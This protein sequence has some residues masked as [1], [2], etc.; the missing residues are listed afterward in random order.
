MR[1]STGTL[2]DV[3]ELSV[4]FNEYRKFY[5]QAPDTE[6]AIQF[7]RER[8]MNNES[9]I[10]LS[11]SADGVLTGFVQLYPIFSSTRMRRLWLLNDLF[12]ATAFRGAGVS[13]ALIEKAKTFSSET[14]SCGL[15]LETEKSNAIAN[16][17]YLKTGFTLDSNHNY[18]TWS[19][20]G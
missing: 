1:I 11:R 14:T 6:N 18:Y 19:D 4:L 3:E 20:K 9:V 17:L 8:I 15:L 16:G 5:G 10:F 13:V 2:D 12:V 7:L